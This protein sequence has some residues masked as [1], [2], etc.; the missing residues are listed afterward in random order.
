MYWADHGWALGE[1]GMWCKMAN[2]ELQTRVPLII[3][4]PW[5]QG[6]KGSSAAMVELVD[7]VS[8]IC[9]DLAESAMHARM[10]R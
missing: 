8:G 9:A 4:A 2:F 5:L 7:M 6:A 3:R 1:Q 10:Y